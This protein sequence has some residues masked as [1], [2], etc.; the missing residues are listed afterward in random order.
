MECDNQG[1]CFRQYFARDY[2]QEVSILTAF[3]KRAATIKLLITFNGKSFDWPFLQNRGIAHC[4]RLRNPSFHLDLL[5]ESRRVYS[6]TL[7][8][9]KLQTLERCVCGRTRE[10]DIPGSEIPA[11]YHDFVR[12]GN[13][14]KISLIL[15]HNLHDL[16]TMAD[17]MRKIWR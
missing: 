13:A 3:A 4:V 15:R 8:N 1:F 6:R 9:C 11:A 2:S 12:T 10:D 7:P 17:L 14:N 16:L 5:H